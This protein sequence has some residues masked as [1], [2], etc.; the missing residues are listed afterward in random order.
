MIH[1]MCNQFY[2]LDGKCYIV[3]P[4]LSCFAC[5]DLNDTDGIW[6][7]YYPDYKYYSWKQLKEKPQEEINALHIATVDCDAT[8]SIPDE[9]SLDY[10]EENIRTFRLN[11]RIKVYKVELPDLLKV[12]KEIKEGENQ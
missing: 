8:K 1:A 9:L 5:F 10:I 2:I 11:P 3:S 6:I 12:C 7:N 4:Y